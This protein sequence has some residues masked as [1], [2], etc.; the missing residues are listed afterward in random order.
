METRPIERK[1]RAGTAAVA[2]YLV[3][4]LLFTMRLLTKEK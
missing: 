3:M 4:P 2:V 1:F